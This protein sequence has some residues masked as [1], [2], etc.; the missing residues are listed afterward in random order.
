MERSNRPLFLLPPSLPGVP[1]AALGKEAKAPSDRSDDELMLL[2]RGGA[3]DAFDALIERHQERILRVAYRC[4]GEA[5]LAADAAQ[6]TFLEVFRAL[7]SYQARG[8]FTAFLY[9]VLLN[10]CRMTKRSARAERRALDASAERVGLDEASMLAR[11]HGRDLQRA[12][13]RL[14]DKLRDVVVLRYG[15]DL[16]YDEIAETLSIPVGTVKRRL[17]DAMA[18]LREMLED[19]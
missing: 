14:S 9:V 2:A 17:F 4:L 11:E 19:A 15:A 8:K 13:A 3:E 5:A 6:N 10:Q 12:L 1:P 18:K 7:S 16:S